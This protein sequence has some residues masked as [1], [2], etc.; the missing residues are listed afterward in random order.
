VS[1]E[2]KKSLRVVLVCKSEVC[3]VEQHPHH[4]TPVPCHCVGCNVRVPPKFVPEYVRSV[5]S[6]MGALQTGGDYTEQVEATNRMSDITE[7]PFM[8]RVI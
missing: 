8:I 4:S 6:L 5:Q 7:C 1:T 2:E 3:A